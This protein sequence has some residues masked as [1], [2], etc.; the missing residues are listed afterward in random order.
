[1]S[2][3]TI[4]AL[5]K[6]CRRHRNSGEGCEDPVTL[7]SSLQQNVIDRSAARSSREPYAISRQ[8]KISSR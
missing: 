2:S 6:S 1:M 7:D 4:G 3:F 5:C 8:I